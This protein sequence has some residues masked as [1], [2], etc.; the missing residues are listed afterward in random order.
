MSENP[1]GSKDGEYV[2][3]FQTNEDGSLY[4]DGSLPPDPD[5]IV[6]NAD[7]SVKENGSLNADGSLY[8]DGSLPPIPETLYE[9]G[10][11]EKRG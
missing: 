5:W 1:A 7:G 4:W 3:L 8:W 9:D 11:E 6:F 10:G 2:P